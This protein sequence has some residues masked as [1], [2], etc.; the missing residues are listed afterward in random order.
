MKRRHNRK[1]LDKSNVVQPNVIQPN[2]VQ[3][4]ITQPNV[5]QPNIVQ[6]NIVQPNVVQPNIVQP[7]VVHPNVV[8]SNVV[9]PNV[10]LSNVTPP[11]VVFADTSSLVRTSTSREIIAALALKM[12]PLSANT[13]S[14][15]SLNK[16]QL[17]RSNISK[18]SVQLK[19]S[20]NKSELVL[21]RSAER[22][23]STTVSEAQYVLIVFLIFLIKPIFI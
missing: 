5:V 3:S 11:D 20:L 7:I 12:A 2:S 23:K 4:N 21:A 18:P 16:S 9:Q 17:V 15:Q 8:Q 13:K 14:Q 1:C 19:T 10:V 6:S 22:W